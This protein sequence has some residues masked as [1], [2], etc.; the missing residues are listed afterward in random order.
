M[1]LGGVL[2]RGGRLF[3]SGNKEA[4]RDCNQQSRNE[5]KKRRSR[6]FA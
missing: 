3:P 5:S 6:S 2:P 1:W 4:I